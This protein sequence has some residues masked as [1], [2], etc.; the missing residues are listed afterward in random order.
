V[1]LRARHERPLR[2]GRAALVDGAREQLAAVVGHLVQTG[3]RRARTLAEQRHAL[4]VSAERGDVRADPAQ[5]HHLVLHA[6][7]TCATR[8]ANNT[9]ARLNARSHGRDGRRNSRGVPKGHN[10][11]YIPQELA[12]V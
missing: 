10:G 3:A 7:V 8:P 5:D 12:A 2:V 9:P 6:E 4:H 1:R 11:I